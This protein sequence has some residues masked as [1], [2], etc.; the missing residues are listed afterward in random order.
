[1]EKREKFDQRGKSLNKN[2]LRNLPQYRDMPEEELD[3]IIANREVS[4]E[5]SKELEK[6]V[7]NKLQKFAEDYDLSDMKENDKATLRAMIQAILSLEDYEQLAYKLRL[8]GVTTEN[9]LAVDKVSKIMEGLRK[10]ISDFQNDLNITRK[11]RKSDQETSV[12]AYIESLKQKAREYY[13]S[14]MSYVFCNKCHTLLATIWTLYPEED[15]KIQLVCMQKDK[16]GNPCRNKVTVSTKELL[17][18]KG[19]ND[20]EIMPDALL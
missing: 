19:T 12:L 15:N 8:E 20:R 18:K 11:H 16:A 7:E 17:E 14:R 6:R 10:G 9:I 13:E 5:T 1:M 2:K 3:L 4:I